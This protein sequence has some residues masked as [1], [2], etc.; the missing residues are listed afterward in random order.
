MNIQK[1][2]GIFSKSAEERCRDRICMF[3]SIFL[4]Y[5]ML[6]LLV[7]ITVPFSI[8]T[9]WKSLNIPSCSKRRLNLR[10]KLI[11]LLY[12][13]SSRSMHNASI[14]PTYTAATFV[15]DYID[16]EIVFLMICFLTKT[17]SNMIVH[18][19]VKKEIS[20]TTINFSCF[21]TTNH[22]CTQ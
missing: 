2:C 15:S 19:L 6:F 9:D 21:Y 4:N 20:G 12:S 17:F 11:S 14:I 1:H 18:H 10:L 5:C 22:L 13:L 3:G 8:G 16:S 7:M